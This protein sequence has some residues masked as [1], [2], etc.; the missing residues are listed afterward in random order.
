[1]SR[2]ND[3]QVGG[4]HYKN[5]FQHWDLCHE[6]DL[7]Y[8][9]GQITKYITRHRFKKGKED[10]DKALH[11]CK[12]L[13][14]LVRNGGRRPR[15]LPATFKRMSEYSDA[16]RLEAIEYACLVGT[17]NWQ[18]IDDLM[19]LQER[20]KRLIGMYYPY[21]VVGVD[22]TKEDPTDGSEPNASYLNQG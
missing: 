7:G 2:A 10:A 14:E 13:I 21:R 8:F 12:K 17:C 15:Y 4:T 1:M 22:A 16:N 6:L 3:T 18:T 9:E 20:I 19:A 5:S 11:F